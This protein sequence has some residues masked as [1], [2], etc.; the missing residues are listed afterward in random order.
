MAWTALLARLGRAR[1]IDDPQVGES[2]LD[3]SIVVVNRNTRAFLLPCLRSIFTSVPLP[4]LEVIVVDQRSPDGSAEAVRNSY[5]RAL[6]LVNASDRGFGHA[7]NLGLRRARGRY[8]LTLNPDTL[9]PPHALHTLVQWM[10]AHPTV[11]VVGPKLV[12][13]DGSL[14]L[15]CRRTFPTPATALYRLLG[16][17]RLFPRSR[18]LARYNLTYLDPDQPAE[19]NSVSGA[20]MSGAA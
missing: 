4:K 14:D 6:L 7:N 18:T 13:A 10:D 17:S 8:L 16:L 11:G 15:A 9:L 5:P 3:L 19:V 2:G 12:R 1:Y 20:F